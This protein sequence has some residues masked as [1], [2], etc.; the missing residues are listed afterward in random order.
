MDR[1][2]L[3]LFM[4]MSGGNDW[5]AYYDALRPLPWP[6]R[7]FF[8]IYISFALFAVVNI[9]TG[10][11]VDSAMQS[12]SEDKVITAHEELESKK[13]YLRAMREIFNEMD[14]DDTGSISLME[15]E[16]KLS[17]E[18]VVAYF[19]AMKLDVSDARKLFL[20]IDHD[21]SDEVDIDEFVTGCYKLQGES[22]SLDVKLMQYELNFVR[23]G[24]SKISESVV[25]IQ[26]CVRA[27]QSSKS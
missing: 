18:R 8:L 27:L 14:E 26:K 13:D 10:V 12:N 20:L 7:C 1:S 4:A 9:V 23:E 24:V 5:S 2:M 16:K 17:D 19:S 11:F 21:H 6:Y 15:F 25:G 3:A 22:R